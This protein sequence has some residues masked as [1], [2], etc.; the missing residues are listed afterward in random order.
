MHAADSCWW[1]LAASA[2]REHHIIG[3]VLNVSLEVRNIVHAIDLQRPQNA[4]TLRAGSND[5]A[6]LALAVLKAPV[7]NLVCDALQPE[8]AGRRSAQRPGLQLRP[9]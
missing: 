2:R 5:T 7:R 8:A 3:N 9:Q 6:V 4:A 1:S